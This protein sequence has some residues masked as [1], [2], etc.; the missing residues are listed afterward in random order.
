[1]LASNT[2]PAPRGA[3]PNVAG[4]PTRTRVTLADRPRLAF[5]RLLRRSAPH[6]GQLPGRS[7]NAASRAIPVGVVRSPTPP[8]SPASREASCGTA[9]TGTGNSP[10]APGPAGAQATRTEADPCRR[11][12]CSAAHTPTMSAMESNAPTS[13]KW[14]FRRKRRGRAPRS[15]PGG[16]TPPRP[17]RTDAGR[18]AASRSVADAA[19]G[20]E[21]GSSTSTRT[22]I[23]S[24]PQSGPGHDLRSSLTEPG[25]TGIDRPL[26][27][28][29]SAPAS[30]SAPSS[31][32]PAIP[33]EASIQA[34]SRLPT[35]FCRRIALKVRRSGPPG[36]RRRSRCRC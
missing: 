28:L 31:M 5:R 17:A 34:C 21:G 18:S 4:P 7:A 10:W 2:T 6:R 33:A 36:D 30:I 29:E 13:W 9:G 8:A 25:T 26:H 3:L 24:R 1:M 20:S 19:P 22:S 32:S 15:R 23:L 12:T 16:R 14:T 11:P 35:G 27:G